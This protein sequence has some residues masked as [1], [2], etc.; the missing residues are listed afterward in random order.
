MS[1]SA[2]IDTKK[3]S[4]AEILEGRID[5]REGGPAVSILGSVIGFPARFEAIGTGFPF[6]VM[7][8]VQTEVIEDP[9]KPKTQGLELSI[10]PRKA[11]GFLGFLAHI[12]LFEGRGMS[13]HDR[14]L[15]S[16]FIFTYNDRTE[17]ERFVK[18][19]GVAECL[20]RLHKY[21][22]FSD[23]KIKA[24]AGIF[25][26]QSKSFKALDLDV[27]RVT[28]KLLGEIGQVLFEAF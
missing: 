6:G 23:L 12:F 28:F 27:C 9:S 3:K 1:K 17:A 13:V 10:C 18:Y 2:V 11:S 4:V 19:P 21:T 22:E 24:N 15:D 16:L 20:L 26:A 25:L 7:Y 14:Q 5:D 8:F